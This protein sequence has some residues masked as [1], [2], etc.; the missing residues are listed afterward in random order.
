MLPEIIT[1]PAVTIGSM[2][3]GGELTAGDLAVMLTVLWYAAQQTRDGVHVDID[4]KVMRNG[5]FGP[6]KARDL[7][8]DGERLGRLDQTR[9]FF[10]ERLPDVQNGVPAPTIDQGMRR[11]LVDGCQRWTIDTALQA[12]F[13]IHDNDDVVQVP[14]ALLQRAK[15]RFSTLLYMRVA[16]WIEGELD[17]KWI[18]RA[19][20]D[21]LLLRVPLQEVK[22][23]VGFGGDTAQLAKYVLAPA[24]S[25]ITTLTDWHLNAV[26]VRAPGRG[27][28]K[29]L[30]VD[31]LI[32][33]P[34]LVTPKPRVRKPKQQEL[35]PNVVRLPVSQ[36]ITQRPVPDES[37]DF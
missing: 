27:L 10:D 5:L 26:L 22:E 20:E 6:K 2:E 9:L 21:K 35:P 33:R 13:R 29:V 34:T 16:A 36:R 7:K 32:G 31:F 18:R 25:E 14:L 23:A 37:I 12:A 24:I 11:V 8:R 15:C 1:F 17:R 28:G 3:V 19:T 30:A 4:E